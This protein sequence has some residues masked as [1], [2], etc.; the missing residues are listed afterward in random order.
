MRHRFVGPVALI[1]TGVLFL[2]DEFTRYEWG[3]TWPIL[4]IAIGVALAAQRAMNPNDAERAVQP[5]PLAVP[6]PDPS[7]SEKK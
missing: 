3:Q 4:L 2:L 7:S 1:T 6:G 5:T